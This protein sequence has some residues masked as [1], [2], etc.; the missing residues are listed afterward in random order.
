MSSDIKLSTCKTYVLMTRAKTKLYLNQEWYG[1]WLALLGG[2][3]SCSLQ[4]VRANL[5]VVCCGCS[6]PAAGL[7]VQVKN[8]LTSA[9]SRSLC[10]TCGSADDDA[11]AWLLSVGLA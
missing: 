3:R 10:I 2:Q 9:D 6:Q 8:L 4:F 5:G 11:K 1:A 7:V